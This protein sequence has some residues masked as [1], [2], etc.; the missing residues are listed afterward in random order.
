MRTKNTIAQGTALKILTAM[1]YATR[2]RSQDAPMLQRAITTKQP[3]MIMALATTL[4]TET[5]TAQVIGQQR[6]VTDRRWR[7]DGWK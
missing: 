2:L 6:R 7:C 5:P 3:R 1:A 4:G